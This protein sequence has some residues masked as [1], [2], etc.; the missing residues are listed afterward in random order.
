MFT[1]PWF[2]NY[3]HYFEL[4]F[5]RWK[6]MPLRLQTWDI[7]M[8]SAH[9][10]RYNSYLH[11]R[12]TCRCDSTFQVLAYISPNFYTWNVETLL[13]VVFGVSQTFLCIS[14]LYIRFFHAKYARTEFSNVL[15]RIV[16]SWQCSRSACSSFKLPQRAVDARDIR[17]QYLRKIL[18]IVCTRVRFQ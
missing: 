10:S 15:R 13:S 1:N 16:D 9:R 12:H 7:P 8:H 14:S 17:L 2:I 11:Q 5:H 6:T 4:Y 18:D 3:Y